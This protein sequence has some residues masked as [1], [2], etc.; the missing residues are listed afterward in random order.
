MRQI[1]LALAA[2]AL[3]A[4]PARAQ[5]APPAF[6]G[7]TAEALA[8]SIA[9]PGIDADEAAV[10]L[11]ALLA[12]RNAY[13]GPVMPDEGKA[14]IERLSQASEPVDVMLDGKP[15]KVGPLLPD[16]RRFLQLAIIGGPP[17]LNLWQSTNPE[18]RLHMVRIY[19]LDVPAS[20]NG[21]RAMV[22][23]DMMAA[24]SNSTVG[25]SYEP[26]RK[27]IGDAIRLLDTT[28]PANRKAGRALIVDA[29]KWVDQTTSDAVPD[30]LY[31]WVAE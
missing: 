30:Y 10:I 17:E 28:T 14:L 5:Q 2:A 27:S 24:W 8:Q 6:G 7:A 26:L 22:Y 19:A 31:T 20:N 13:G 18:I 1:G 3:V 16:G 11:K 15:Q 4:V 21:V 29:M 9:T 23:Q 12:T 25:N